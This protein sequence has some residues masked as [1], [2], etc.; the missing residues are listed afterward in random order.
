MAMQAQRARTAAGL[1]AATPPVDGL[2]STQLSQSQKDDITAKMH[3]VMSACEGALLAAR[4]LLRHAAGV[5]T[6]VHALP[7]AVHPADQ[8]ELGEWTTLQQVWLLEKLSIDRALCHTQRVTC[9]AGLLRTDSS[10]V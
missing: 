1:S 10:V 8:E 5:L 7:V 9:N 6:F 3:S 2:P 4:L